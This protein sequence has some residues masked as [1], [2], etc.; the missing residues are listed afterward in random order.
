M[1][2]SGTLVVNV[3]DSKGAAIP[4]LE[5]LVDGTKR[6]ESAPCIVRDVPAGVHE[7]KVTAKGF[8]LA[9]PRAVTVDKKDVAL[10]FQLVPTK[11]SAGTGFK[12]SSTRSGVKLQVD[13]KDIGPLPQEMRDLEPGEHKL[14]FVGDRYAP[15]EKTVS[16]AK[17]EIVDL[18]NVE[19]KVLKGK[20]TLQLGTPGAKVYLVNGSNRKEVPQ[21]P[22]AIEFDPSERWELQATKDGFEEYKERISFDDGQAEKTFNVTLT[23]KGAAATPTPTAAAQ[24]FAAAQPAAPTPKAAPP[25]PK[26]TPTAEPKKEPT[27]GGGGGGGETVLKINSIP[28]SS[29]VLDGKPIGTT[30]QLHVVVSPGSHTVMFVNSELSLKKTI[31]VEVKAG[32]TKPAFAKL[33]E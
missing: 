6:C 3:A 27:G 19:L 26:E 10:D 20:A 23:P 5:V 30:P 24:P 8:E 29:V 9:A 4:S 2:R 16:V 28:A 22:M 18:G 21:F 7:V 17:D 13:G 31:T 11:A 33:R 12:V 32:E 14:R 25:T 15:L 1:P